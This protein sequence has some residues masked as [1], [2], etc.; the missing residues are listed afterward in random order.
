MYYTIKVRYITGNSFGS[1]EEEDTIGLCW[2]SIELA[3]K[4]LAVIEEHYKIYQK[5][6]VNCWQADRKQTNKKLISQVKKTQW[7]QKSIEQLAEDKERSY[8]MG[9][10][11]WYFNCAVELDDGS[12]RN[13]PT[14]MWCGYFE[15]L[16]E[17]SVY[18]DPD[19]N[20]QD[21]KTF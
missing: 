9:D 19:D 1:H 4:A 11:Y 5:V 17:A 3:R 12:F 7:Y 18:V 15:R 13:I 6:E 20:P 21:Y 16:L 2:Q 14:D 8:M 10:N